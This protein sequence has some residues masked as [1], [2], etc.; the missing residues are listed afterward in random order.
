MLDC[1]VGVRLVVSEETTTNERGVC[2]L[3]LDYININYLFKYD[4]GCG[5]LTCFK[6]IGFIRTDQIIRMSLGERNDKD[7]EHCA[8]Y[9]QFMTKIIKMHLE[10][11]I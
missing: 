4:S 2:K 1:G 3:Q 10:C 11:I 5:L 8:K 6:Y 9:T 7:I